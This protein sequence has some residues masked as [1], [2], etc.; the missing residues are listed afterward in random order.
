MNLHS[1]QVINR[2]PDV[3]ILCHHIGGLTL[4]SETWR[5]SIFAKKKSPTPKKLGNLWFIDNSVDGSNKSCT[6]KLR[7][8]VYF[9]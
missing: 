6:C 3:P 5:N 9:P 2:R 8:V 1:L 4:K 7:L